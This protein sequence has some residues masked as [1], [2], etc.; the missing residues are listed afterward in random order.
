MR[1]TDRS[2]FFLLICCALLLWMG[3]ASARHA[4]VA[5][6]TSTT[7]VSIADDTGL[8]D[9]NGAWHAA[10]DPS[11][12]TFLLSA[13]NDDMDDELA[14]PAPMLVRLDPLRVD[15]PAG[16]MLPLPAAAAVRLPRPP[17]LA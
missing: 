12:A 17:D 2:G 1:S 13:D 14:L 5:K 9:R 11:P 3:A 10:T 16:T 8:A 6:A 15:M 4:P 7:A